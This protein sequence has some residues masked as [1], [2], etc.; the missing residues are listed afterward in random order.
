MSPHCFPLSVVQIGSED[1]CH[2]SQVC[3]CLHNP[4][5]ILLDSVV[6]V[7]RAATNGAQMREKIELEMDFPSPNST[8]SL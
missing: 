1:F 6:V 8:Y 4:N 3:T 5:E 2:M 7:S